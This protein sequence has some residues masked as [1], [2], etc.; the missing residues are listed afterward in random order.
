MKM[1]CLAVLA[2]ALVLAGCAGLELAAVDDSVMVQVEKLALT[3]ANVMKVPEAGGGKVVVLADY[4]SKAEGSVILKE[5]TYDVTV[6]AL[7]VS[8]D[9]DAF[10]LT[11][12]DGYKERL[13]PE[14]KGAIVPIEIGRHTQAAD[15]ACKI[16]F[17]FG[18]ENVQLDQILFKK[19]EAF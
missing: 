16:V 2:V 6:F 5:G 1:K 15:G 11:L 3:H 4:S 7:G 18:E 19:V 13:Y 14:E 9:E 17:G 8:G 12:A 10:Y